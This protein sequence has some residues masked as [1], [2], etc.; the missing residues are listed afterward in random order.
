[1]L[2]LD[3]KPRMSVM[4]PDGSGKQTPQPIEFGD[5]VI[6][7]R[8]MKFKADYFAEVLR[9][10]GIPV[11]S[12]GGGGF[13]ESAEIRDMLSLLRVLDNQRQDIPLA[14]FLRSP[15]ADVPQPDECLARI[16][17]AYRDEAE[18]IPFH[19]A[20]YRYAQEQN[21]E[22]AAHLRWLFARLEEWRDQANKRPAA[23]LIW[24]IYQETGY[25]A[26]VS[27]LEDGRQRVANLLD[28]HDRAAQFSHFLRQ[29]LGRFLRFLESLRQEQDPQRPSPA[30]D[31]QN[32]VRIMSIHRAKGLEFPVVFLPDLGK[33]H[34][35]K[36]AQGAILADRAAGLGMQV[37]DERRFIR[38]D[39]VSS[40][41]VSHSLHRQ[42]IAEELRLLYVA[43]TR[44]KEHLVC[45]GTCRATALEEWENLW[46]HHTG[47]CRRMSCW[48]RA[49]RSFGLGR[50]GG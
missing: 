37:V 12:D 9:A 26:Y 11:H 46:R 41:L 45:V 32:V 3:G 2:G 38:H 47:P 50:Y 1:M 28:L 8:A 7:L 49:G 18:E 16:H 48:A 31:A 42:T 44:A 43:M 14:A 34:N 19:Q 15:L 20:V 29:G 17:L 6:L 13:F 39:S 35:L 10:A 25:L 27:G 40:T 24:S 36:D 5:I 4:R 22:W 21:D 33:A 30:A 23:D